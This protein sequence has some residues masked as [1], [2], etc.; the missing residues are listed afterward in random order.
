MSDGRA[1]PEAGSLWRLPPEE[2][3]AARDALARR[4]RAAGR[5][6]EADAVKALRKPTRDA[7]AVNRLVAEEPGLVEAV[8][9]VGERLRAAQ[10]QR[11]GDELRE[12]AA[13]RERVLDAA[14]AGAER[15]CGPLTTGVRDAV[16]GTLLAALADPQAAQLVRAGS[17]SSGLSYAGLGAAPLSSVPAT[18]SRP[19][20]PR[21]PVPPPPGREEP[22]K[23]A[24]R[25]V[26][27]SE[28]TAARARLRAA[29]DELTA[30]QLARAEAQQQLDDLEA[31]LAEARS[32]LHDANSDVRAAS[33]RRDQA[34]RLLSRLESGRA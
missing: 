14:L 27:D 33:T 13:E 12:L 9:E 31:E 34:A 15:I 11:R 3:T 19:T 30:A 17:L 21:P 25:T 23:P 4:L 32:A 22:V 7:C 6:A 1:V 28:L 5:R 10:V 24:G 20:V 26:S 18:A 16:R 29:E 2:F 8:V